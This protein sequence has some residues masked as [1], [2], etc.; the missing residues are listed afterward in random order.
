MT[1]APSRMVDPEVAVLDKVSRSDVVA[2]LMRAGA[3]EVLIS[4]S[5]VGAVRHCSIAAGGER[6]FTFWHVLDMEEYESSIAYA[7]E[8]IAREIAGKP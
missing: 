7:K 8:W 3:D 4:P 6:L 5:E 2:E 1:E